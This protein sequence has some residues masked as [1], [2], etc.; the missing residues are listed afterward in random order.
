[1]STPTTV[2]GKSI[3]LAL[4][5]DDVTYKNIVCSKAHDVTLDSSV[6]TEVSDCG[7]H[8]SLNPVES[9]W[10]FQ[11][12]INTTPNGATEM[13]HDEIL[14][15][16]NN[17]TKVYLKTQPATKVIKGYGYISNFVTTKATENLMSYSFTF[18]VDGTLTITP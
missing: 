18:V 6:N 9:T 4:S 15:L 17:Q 11:G 10:T 16:A 1:M 7:T 5:L 12:L 14:L 8:R 3:P 2:Q 13:G